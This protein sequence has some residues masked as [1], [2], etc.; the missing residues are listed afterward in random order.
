MLSL[1]KIVALENFVPFPVEIPRQ[2]EIVREKH[3]KPQVDVTPKAK[4][5][6]ELVLTG[7]QI[8]VGLMVSFGAVLLLTW[9][10]VWFLFER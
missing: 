4:T 7:W 1:E 8:L 5:R 6:G 3:R 9:G 10:T 2:V